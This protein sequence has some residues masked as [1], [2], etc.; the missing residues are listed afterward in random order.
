[1]NEISRKG[2]FI[3]SYSGTIF[4][5]DSLVT[6]NAKN[7]TVRDILDRIFLNMAD[8]RE[9]ANYVI[10]RSTIRRFSIQP[11]I[12]KTDQRHYLISGYVIDEQTGKKVPEASVYEKRLLES[13]LTDK[14]GYFRMRIRGSHQSVIL[15]LSKES[16]RDT[17]MMFLSTVTIKPEGYTY[18]DEEYMS[19]ASNI[20]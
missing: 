4:N 16:Y 5:P 15:T 3:F 20:V 9:S 2:N 19:Y 10:L 13:D 1:M 6:L 8:Y 12:I 14:D 11:D 7:E 17:S 18:E